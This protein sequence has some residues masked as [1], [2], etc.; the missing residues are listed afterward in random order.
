MANF[1]LIHGGFHGAWCWAKLGPLLA[2]QGHGVAALD[3][4]GNGADMT[5]HDQITL[6]C[7]AQKICGVLETADAPVILVGHSLGGMSIS[8]AAERMPG[9]IKR[10]VY[11]AGFIPR[12]GQSLLS[13]VRETSTLPP[14]S[15]TFEDG[16]T[17][18]T[19][20]V[21][22]AEES[23]A[24]FYNDCSEEDIAFA[25]PRLKPQVNAPRITP[26]R[27][28]EA[29]FGSVPR[30][31][32]ACEKDNAMTPERRK[33]VAEHGGC[34][35]VLSLPT[36]HSPFFSAPEMLAVMLDAISELE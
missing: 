17:G 32:I 9:R 12:D 6:E 2:E 33:A 30:I 19:Q 28:T 34:E 5:P 29:R 7:Y 24:R 8:L 16:W 18:L 21:P 1:V 35:K 22:S 15:P 23:I 3:M 13:S 25:L 11:L 4:P 14:G 10:L 20:P 26:V 31:F 36:G 27:L